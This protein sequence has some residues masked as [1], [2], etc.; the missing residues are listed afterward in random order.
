MIIFLKQDCAEP[1]NLPDHKIS[2]V[3]KLRKGM[4][5]ISKIYF[6]FQQICRMIKVFKCKSYSQIE[7][8]VK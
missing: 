6:T 1:L 4:Q 7:I 3:L 2:K 5:M 8:K